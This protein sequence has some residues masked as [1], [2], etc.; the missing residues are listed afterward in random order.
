MLIEFDVGLHRCGTR[1]HEE[2]IALARRSS[3]CPACACVA[4]SA[5]RATACS[6]PTGGC[7]AKRRRPPTTRCSGSSTNSTT[8]PAHGD[9]RRRRTRHLG[10]HRRQPAHHRDPRRLLHLHGRVPPQPRPRLRGRTHGA[11]D[12]IS[13]SGPM[14]VLDGGR[15]AIGID[16]TLPELIGGEAVIRFEH[17]EHFIHE[18]HTAIVLRDGA[19]PRH[20]RP[21]RA[22]ARLR[23]D[24]RQPLRHLLRCRRRPYPRRLAN[25]RALRKRERRSGVRWSAIARECSPRVEHVGEHVAGAPL[26]IDLTGEPGREPDPSCS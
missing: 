25:R 24:D 1:T 19:E 26:E 2:A 17:G 12:I 13:R 4:Y 18:E 9:R 22:D 16:R 11:R 10:H 15:K 21:R 14:A 6:S 23:T 5:T 8:R 3:A 20:R 7:G